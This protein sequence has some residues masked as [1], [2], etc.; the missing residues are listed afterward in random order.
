MRSQESEV[1][2]LRAWPDWEDAWDTQRQDPF[3]HTDDDYWHA[4]IIQII[5][6]I[7]SSE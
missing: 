5:V 2:N 1:V 3:L 6:T 7:T 4:W